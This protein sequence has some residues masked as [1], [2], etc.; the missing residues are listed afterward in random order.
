MTSNASDAETV[1]QGH[2]ILRFGFALAHNDETN[3]TR[4]MFR[5]GGNG[6]HNSFLATTD[7]T[8]SVWEQPQRITLSSTKEVQ[9]ETFAY[10]VTKNPGVDD[11]GQD[12]G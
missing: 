1:P 12:V 4:L 8:N 2:N 10:V 6:K 7:A 11:A 9:K 5:S 3:N